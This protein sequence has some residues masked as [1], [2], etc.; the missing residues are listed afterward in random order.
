MKNKINNSKSNKFIHISKIHFRK[1]VT[2]YHTI[3]CLHDKACQMT[4]IFVAKVVQ[5][6]FEQFFLLPQE[7]SDTFTSLMMQTSLQCGNSLIFEI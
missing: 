5:R 3:M 2:N 1:N 7:K 6:T 4:G